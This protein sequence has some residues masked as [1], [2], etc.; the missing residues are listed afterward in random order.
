MNI[1]TRLA[2]PLVIAALIISPALTI[3][4]AGQSGDGSRQNVIW[5]GLAN[6]AVTGNSLEKTAGLNDTADAGARS[7]QRIT[8]GNAYFEFTAGRLNRTAFCGLTSSAIGTDFAEI[9]FSIKLTDSNVAEVR[10]N[11]IYR[12]ETSYTAGDLFRIAINSGTVIYYKNGVILYVSRTAP[13]F[14]MFV[15]AVLINI[16]ARIDDA[17]IGALTVNSE[18]EWPMYQR[19]PAHT[20]FST[21]SNISAANAGQLAEAWRFQANDQVTG[22]PVVAGGVVYAGSWDVR[23]YALREADGAEIWRYNA[24]TITIDACDDTYGID[25]TAALLDGRLYF[26]TGSAKLVALNAATGAEVCTSQLADPEQAYHIYASP[27]VFD[28]K[29]YIGLASHCVNPCVRGRLVCV[30]ATDGRVLWSFDTAP[31]G[32][33]GGAVWSSVAVDS[34]RRMLY[35]GTGN[36]CAGEDTHSSAILALNADTGSLIWQFKRLRSDTNNLDFGAS[37][38]LFDIAN[39]PALAVGS[40]DGNCYAVNRET[41]ELLWQTRVTDGSSIG[42]I[43]SSPAAAYGRIFMGSIVESRSGKVVALDQRTGEMLWQSPQPAAIIGAAAVAGGALFIGGADGR[44]RA[45]DVN[46]GIELWSAQRGS[47]VGGVSISQDRVLVG[48]NDNSVYA[49]APRGTPPATPGQASITVTSPVAGDQVRKGK[50]FDVTWTYAG[51]SRVDVS[52]SHDN[53]ATW[54]LAGDDIEAGLGA[55]RVKAKKPKSERVIVQVADSS[56]PTIFGRS[57]LFRIR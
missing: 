14:P 42:G 38:V 8:G 49:F 15:S 23:M 56:N 9:D 26:A 35:V 46:S 6:C 48:S 25:S 44:L 53:G 10:E 13:R 4:S 19:D 43:L 37:P 33:T 39:T 54:R 31:A 1:L 41:G 27:A 47:I 7:Q 17:G 12:T 21:E 16:G 55:L 30:S 29:I 28:G 18:A 2:C 20:G 52:I 50:R 11:N 51:V 3:K 5:T 40:K 32:S 22:T 57:G 45:Y 24:G 36:Y 34:R